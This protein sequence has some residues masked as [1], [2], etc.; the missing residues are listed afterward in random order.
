MRQG[1]QRGLAWDGA[2][3]C[4][5]FEAGCPLAVDGGK[6]PVLRLQG[7]SGTAVFQSFRQPG[8]FAAL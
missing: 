3:V 4:S 5:I 6:G 8:P 2:S 1:Y 7:L